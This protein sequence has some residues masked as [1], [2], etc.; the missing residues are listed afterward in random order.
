[1]SRILDRAAGGFRGDDGGLNEQR[2]TP[3]RDARILAVGQ[4]GNRDAWVVWHRYTATPLH[5][6]T[7]PSV[8][9][10]FDI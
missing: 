4:V 6:Y 5:R 1:M 2:V 8:E 3:A 7:A 10:L 9:S